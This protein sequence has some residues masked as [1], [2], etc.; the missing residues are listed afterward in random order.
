MP[1]PLDRLEPLHRYEPFQ[2]GHIYLCTEALT[3]EHAEL[4]AWAQTIHQQAVAQGF[5]IDIRELP[6]PGAGRWEVTTYEIAPSSRLR[7]NSSRPSWRNWP[8]R[9]GKV[10]RILSRRK[11]EMTDRQRSPAGDRYDRW[12]KT[13]GVNVNA[14]LHPAF[15]AVTEE[16]L[17]EELTNVPQGG[18]NLGPIPELEWELLRRELPYTLRPG[19]MGYEIHFYLELVETQTQV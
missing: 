7:N 2:R 16:E 3:D 1:L 14:G 6:Q 19:P 10:K 4:A 9:E 8:L 11:R 17:A 5:R 18:S 12:R 15:W 13:P